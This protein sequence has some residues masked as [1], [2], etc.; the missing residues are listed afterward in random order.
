[1][2]LTS[3]QVTELASPIVDGRGFD[4]EDVTVSRAG[5]RSVVKVVVDSDAGPELDA[6][7]ALSDELSRALDDDASIG[8][9]PFTLE[10][11]S[12]GIDRPLT[13]PRHWARSVGRK[14]EIAFTDPTA[15]P[16]LGRIGA[17]ADGS[18]DIV[19]ADRKKGPSITSVALS[20]VAKA[21][22]QVEFSRPNADELRLCGLDEQQIEARMDVRKD[23]K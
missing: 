20:D 5:A 15:T 22:V 21:L 8:S 1:M 11:T 4:L 13:A 10:V 16:L 2:P 7:A 17:C 18:V 12:R 19:V 6:L 23:D 14:V 9:T 3:E